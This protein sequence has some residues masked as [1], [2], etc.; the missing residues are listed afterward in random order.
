MIF[1]GSVF[2]VFPFEGNNR[3]SV[4]L[5]WRLLAI[6]ALPCYGLNNG[7]LMVLPDIIALTAWQSK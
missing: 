1:C 5:V 3:S 4:A 2:R 6:I 7:A